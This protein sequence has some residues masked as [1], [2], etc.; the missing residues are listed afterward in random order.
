MI[1]HGL[2]INGCSRGGVEKQRYGVC[3]LKVELHN[4]IVPVHKITVVIGQFLSN[5]PK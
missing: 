5:T 4:T 3:Y 2:K 1:T